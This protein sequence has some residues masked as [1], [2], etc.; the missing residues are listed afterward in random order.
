MRA[1]R[2]G[3]CSAWDFCLAMDDRSLRLAQSG[4][5]S[6]ASHANVRL[7]QL[8]T[9]VRRTVPRRWRGCFA[10]ALLHPWRWFILTWLRAGVATRERC[11][12]P[13]AGA[14]CRGKD[15]WAPLDAARCAVGG[16]RPA[17]TRTGGLVDEGLGAPLQAPSS[18]TSPPVHPPGTL[19]RGP[20][21]EIR[22]A[23]GASTSLCPRNAV[24]VQLICVSKRRE[25]TMSRRPSSAM[26]ASRT[27]RGRISGATSPGSLILFCTMNSA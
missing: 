14:R 2:A 24:W 8:P 27:V 9:A 19:P 13:A 11:E 10:P 22:L 6:C 1:V 16:G 26:K 7:T 18:S 3:V 15:S 23:A 12:M 20:P 17:R 25:T 21:L 4:T 5:H